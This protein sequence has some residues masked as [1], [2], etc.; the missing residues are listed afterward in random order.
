MGKIAILFNPAAGKGKAFKKRNELEK[1]LQRFDI[2]YDLIVTRSEEDL[3]ELAREKIESEK[4]IV[5]AGGDST[6]NIILNEIVQK[7]AEVALGMIGLGSSNDVTKEFEIDSLEKA[8][9][10]LKRGRTKRIDVGCITKD[11]KILRC[12]LGQANIGLGV[13]VNK[14]V[15]EMIF[16]KPKVGKIQT[17]AGAFGIINTYSSQQIPLPLT[18]ESERGKIDGNFVLALFNNIRYWATGKKATP[19]ALP[20]DGLLDCCLIKECTL[21]HFAHIVFLSKKGKHASAE[22]VEIFQ[23]KY[24]E[25]SSGKEFE[26]QTDGEILESSGKPSQFKTVGFKVIPRALNIIW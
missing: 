2:K 16:R 11:K 8:C 18:I 7:E 3:K 20:D 19:H 6:F 17:L 9:A 15:E 5:G 23:S 12:Y 21:P 10:A 4:I 14:Y 26:I 1:L 13:L 25:I 22:E 24:F